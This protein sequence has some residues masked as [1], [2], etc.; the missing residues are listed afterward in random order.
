MPVLLVTGGLDEKFTDLA[1]RMAR[2]IGP[3]ASTAVV[4]GTGHA[5][6]LEQPAVVAGL[7]RTFGERRPR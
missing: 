2:A 5:P 4:A 1:R 3:N 7:V 6:H